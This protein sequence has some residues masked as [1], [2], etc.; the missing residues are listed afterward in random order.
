MDAGTADNP[1]ATPSAP[2]A[3]AAPV[4][5]STPAAKPSAAASLA[6]A[7]AAASSAATPT[8]SAPA[9]AGSTTP[10]TGAASAVDT[11]GP[12]PFDRHEQALKNART[13]AAADARKQLEWAARYQQAD[14]EQAIQLAQRLN[15]DS[16]GFL[17]QLARELG[18]A[19]PNAPVQD[20]AEPSPDLVSEDGKKAYSDQALAKILDI[21]ERRLMRQLEARFGPMAETVGAI[22]TERQQTAQQKYYGG[23]ATDA[24]TTARSLPHW[25]EH[26]TD[27]KTRMSTMVQADSTALERFGAV[28]LMYQAYNAILAEQVFPTLGQ[29]TE[30]KVLADLQRKANAEHGSASATGASSAVRQPPKNVSE[31]A[32]HMEALANASA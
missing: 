24:L 4:A 21:R 26:E 18:V 15:S 2:V 12:I 14:V 32:K 28:G 11:R 5:A 20:D 22:T 29:Q 31:L 25:K 13:E 10:A 30:Q 1:S 7:E 16:T 9:H 19:L 6:K 23:I 17:Q 27:I 3:A 8:P